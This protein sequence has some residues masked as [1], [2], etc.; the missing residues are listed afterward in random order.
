MLSE[1]VLQQRAIAAEQRLQQYLREPISFVLGKRRSGA[2]E[3]DIFPPWAELEDEEFDVTMS[4]DAA[5]RV[6]SAGGIRMA[7]TGHGDYYC[8]VGSRESRL[9]AWEL[10]AASDIAD[11]WEEFWADPQQFIASIANPQGY[12]WQILRQ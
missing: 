8:N 6:N 3:V 2:R 4:D 1:E 9:F 10:E 11:D 5:S 7:C 12:R